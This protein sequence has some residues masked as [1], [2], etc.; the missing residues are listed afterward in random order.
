M[1]KAEE[2]KLDIKVM[3]NKE[4][5]KVL[6][7]E[8]GSDF[9]DVLLSVLLLPLGMI[10][11]LL[12]NHYGDRAPIIGSL[13]TLYNGVENLDHVYFHTDAA[14]NMLLNPTCHYVN[15]WPKVGK[16]CNGANFTESAASF[17]ISDDLRVIPNVSGSVIKTLSNLSIAMADMDGAE[18]WNVPFGLDEIMALLK[19]SLISRNPLTA[20]V[21][22]MNSSAG[23]HEHCLGSV[24]S[25]R[26]NMKLASMNPKKMILK[27]MIQKSTNNF[28][29][30]EADNDFI[31]FLFGMLTLP[32][33]RVEWYF[34]SYTGLR[35]M[36]NLH[37]SIQDNL[38]NKHF[39]S[40]V[41]K[42]LL[43]KPALSTNY[44]SCNDL[45]PLNFDPNINQ[46]HV[47]GSR[48]YMVFNDLTV[49][50]LGVMSSVS[51]IRRMKISL[52]DVKELEL[53]VGLGEG[54]SIVKA[55]LTSTTA[56]T[57]GLKPTLKA[58]L[59]SNRSVNQTSMKRLK[60]EW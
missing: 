2:V 7:A 43:L 28:L 57:D 52:S 59:A 22:R 10:V 39:T 32:L 48:M 58:L 29:F 8:A 1:S 31:N 5:S 27:V 34:G 24:F 19:E 6:F 54:L 60:Q 21:L 53:Q 38:N 18:A 47:K 49:E 3:I 37:A 20:L 12:K 55:A 45:I 42:G 40:I 35:G 56:L 17:I 11:K 30:V 26:I 4:K 23:K 16:T 33:G 36:D 46:N 41:T 50:P 14:K 9:T 44:S 15:G 51:V 13:N 25:H